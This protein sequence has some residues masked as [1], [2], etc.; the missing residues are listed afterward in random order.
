MFR[1]NSRLNTDKV[2]I[3]EAK[4]RSKEHPK[5]YAKNKNMERYLLTMKK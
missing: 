3:N 5:F 2:R 4:G 1:F